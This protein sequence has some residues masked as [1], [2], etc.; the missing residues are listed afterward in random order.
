MNIKLAIVI[1]AFKANYFDAALASLAGQ[2]NKNFKVYVCD[3]ASPDDLQT[4]ANRYAEDINITYHR[5]EE[6]M[7]SYNLP[8]HWNRSV[9]LAKEEWVWLFS[10][11]DVMSP[12]CV[13]AFYEA[14]TATNE[15]YNLYRF[16]IEMIDA[17][18]NVICVKAPHPGLESGF[19]FAQRRLHSE[20]LSAAVEYIFKKDV[21]TEKNGFVYF[22][23]A[24]CA[25]DASWVEFAGNK[26]IY[27]IAPEI[28]Y[29]RASGVNI[30][31][32]KGLHMPKIEAMLGYSRWLIN[33]F[34]NQSKELLE[35][36]FL[37]SLKYVYGRV[38]VVQK[39]KIAARLSDLLNKSTFYY[40]IKLLSA[41]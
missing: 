9:K 8:G 1:P 31:S 10:D 39:F 20:S 6:N 3:D 41:N 14:L 26:P 35:K 12:G 27:T 21:F 37:E 23:L 32:V 25:D 22:P 7:G 34:D 11:D 5:F 13:G 38:T 30:S 24:Y 19:E 15:A 36:W 28:V 29:W 16:N 2:T 18:G 33:K 17:A 40:F 4:V